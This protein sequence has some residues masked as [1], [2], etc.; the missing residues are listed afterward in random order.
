MDL[1]GSLEC[2]RGN[3]CSVSQRLKFHVTA[4]VGSLKL[5]YDQLGTSVQ[6]QKIYS[7]LALLP[8]A[9]FLGQDVQIIRD[10]VY[11]GP[12]QTLQIASFLQA[13]GVKVA[14]YK[15]S[16]LIL[17]NFVDRHCRVFGSLTYLDRSEFTT[18]F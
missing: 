4:V 7:P 14:F 3:H 2:H 17:G 13:R 18:L 6:R 12:E 16:K 10:G 9:E 11:L 8:V 1:D 5:D 15:S